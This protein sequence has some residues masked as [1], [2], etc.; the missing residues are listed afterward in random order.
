VL[1]TGLRRRRSGDGEILPGARVSVITPPERVGA[2]PVTERFSTAG[3]PTESE[4][5]YWNLRCRLPAGI[6]K[7][8]CRTSTVMVSPA[9]KPVVSVLLPAARTAR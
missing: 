5:S 6:H 1:R 8:K 9:A 2:T 7:M 3:V 4:M